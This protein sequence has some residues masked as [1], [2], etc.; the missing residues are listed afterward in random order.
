MDK[1]D[2][3][4]STKPCKKH[5]ENP[6]RYPSGGCRQCVLDAGQRYKAK[7]TPDEWRRIRREYD[8]ATS[9]PGSKTD[10]YR[11][12]YRAQRRFKDPAGFLLKEARAQARRR[13]LSFNLERHDVVVPDKCPVLG[14]PIAFTLRERTP[15]T[16][17]L[18]RIDSSKGY[19][20]GNV[21]IVSWR[22]NSIKMDS[23]PDELIAVGKFYKALMKGR[24]ARPTLKWSVRRHN[25]HVAARR[26][27]ALP[28]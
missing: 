27:F 4:V 18:D 10:N 17:S 24:T 14:I 11:K 8:R 7:H 16:P 13:G 19:V 12:R 28:L 6:I 25:A 2:M 22:A 1:L 9:R 15:S 21:I 23:T 20:K 3:E 5:G 26:Q